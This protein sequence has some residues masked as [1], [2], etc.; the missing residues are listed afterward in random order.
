MCSVLRSL[1]RYRRLVVDTLA[2]AWTTTIANLRSAARRHLAQLQRTNI[3]NDGPAILRRH[4]RRV[5]RHRAPTVRHHVEEM[6]HWRLAQT[7]VVIRRRKTEAPPD[8][9]AIAVAGHAVT[10]P[11]EDLIALLA[12]IDRLSRDRR[13]KSINIVGIGC[14][15]SAWGRFARSILHRD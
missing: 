14:A 7:I 2:G 13:G 3:G 4:L 1:L 15:L 12:A 11:A 8:N 6:S 9:H 5:T 10:Y